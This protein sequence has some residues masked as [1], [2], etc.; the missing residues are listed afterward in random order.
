MDRNGER[1]TGEVSWKGTRRPAGEGAELA[2]PA[3][4]VKRPRGRPRVESRDQLLGQPVRMAILTNLAAAESVTF[5][6]LRAVVHTNDGNLSIHARKLERA[7][8]IRVAKTFAGRVPRTE[9]S[10]TP[11][12]RQALKEFQAGGES[13]ASSS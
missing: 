10:L 7:G 11:I 12:G 5:M 13:T 2:G 1:T 6:R 8:Y 4:P 9:Y 3:Q